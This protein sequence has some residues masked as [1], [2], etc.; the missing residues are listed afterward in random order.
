MK[1]DEILRRR[2]LAKQKREAK[3]PRILRVMRH[4]NEKFGP[5][6][7]MMPTTR[8][9]LA[10]LRSMIERAKR[11]GYELVTMANPERPGDNWRA[12]MRKIPD[13]YSI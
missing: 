5:G 7:Y 8:S 1:Q 3:I 13:D 12:I 6:Q 11:D 2:S 9:G 10:G 4:A